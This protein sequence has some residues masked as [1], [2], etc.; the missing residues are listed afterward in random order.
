[1]KNHNNRD[2]YVQTCDNTTHK[3]TT[4]KPHTTHSLLLTQQ[5]QCLKYY[6]E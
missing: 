6:N 2:G 3:A 1:M 4:T 5:A